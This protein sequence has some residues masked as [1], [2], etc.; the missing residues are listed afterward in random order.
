MQPLMQK[1]RLKDHLHTRGEY[2]GDLGEWK[3]RMGSP[4]H[5]WRILI[6]YCIENGKQGIT[7]THVEN[8]LLNV[9]LILFQ[10][11][12]PPHTWRIPSSAF[13]IGSS[14][15]ITSTHVENTAHQSLCRRS[16]WDHLHT[17]G[18]YVRISKMVSRVLGSPP[19]TWRIHTGYTNL[20]CN[21]GITSTHVEN[22]RLNSVLCVEGEDHLHTRG[23]YFMTNSA[24][25]F[26]VG[27]PPHTWRIP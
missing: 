9:V 21:V 14:T 19:H 20:H 23:E 8:T 22:T 6:D 11:G 5:T 18:E 2:R 1:S 16:T 26:Q 17:R 27:S 13:L 15:R 7:S 12:S 4:P 25:R 3:A 10:S 24:I